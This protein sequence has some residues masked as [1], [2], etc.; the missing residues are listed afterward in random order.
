MY[1]FGIQRS[2]GF[3]TVARLID[4]YVMNMNS[5]KFRDAFL[6]KVTLFG[7]IES[8]SD[9]IDWFA[10]R[11]RWCSSYKKLDGLTMEKNDEV[12]LLHAVLE[13]E[14]YKK[15][16]WEKAKVRVCGSSC[17]KRVLMWGVVSGISDCI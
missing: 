14:N 15:V 7:S 1:K 2:L 3:V 17:G 16:S 13:I 5:G 9:K 10:W 4:M 11:Y 8:K 12:L 6:K